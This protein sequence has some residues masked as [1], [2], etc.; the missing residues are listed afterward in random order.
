V[1]WMP[2]ILKEELRDRLQERAEE[3]GV[4]DLVE[5]IADD[6]VAITED[7]VLRYIKEKGHPALDMESI[8]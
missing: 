3:E 5:M 2:R 6:E 7:E 4:P 8:V 1:V